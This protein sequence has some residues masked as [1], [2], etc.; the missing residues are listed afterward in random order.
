VRATAAPL[1][2][3]LAA[4]ALG[5]GCAG[6]PAGE[7]RR[8]DADPQA[9]SRELDVVPRQVPPLL[10]AALAY[11]YAMPGAPDCATL[12]ARIGELDAVLGPDL[13]AAPATRDRHEVQHLVLGGIASATPYL[14][15]VRKLTGVER[16]QR[17]LQSA[18][19]AGAARRGFLKGLGQRSGCRPP[20]APGKRAVDGNQNGAQGQG[21][22][23]T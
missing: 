18:F 1:V 7:H 6:A 15:W 9:A 16:R 3:A 23:G 13:D 8:G 4:L 14:G 19:T 17:L 10:V 11:P 2:V 5:S 21:A 12:A 22:P 20:A